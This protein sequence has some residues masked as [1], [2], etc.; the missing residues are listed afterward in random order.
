MKPTI[1]THILAIK[2][3]NNNS[4]MPVKGSKDAAGYDLFSDKSFTVPAQGKCCVTTG[5]AVRIP[6][7]HYGRIAARSGLAVKKSIHVGAGVI[8]EDST[9]EVKVLLFNHGDEDFNILEG[10]RI[11]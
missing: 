5:I 11:A 3:L 10:D 9:G 6:P 8:N 2:K 4:K 7:E 1:T